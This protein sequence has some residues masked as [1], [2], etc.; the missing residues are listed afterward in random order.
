MKRPES[1]AHDRRLR[2]DQGEGLE[3]PL[4]NKVGEIA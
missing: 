4:Q 2:A 3:M 1:K